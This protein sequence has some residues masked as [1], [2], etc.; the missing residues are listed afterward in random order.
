VHLTGPI[1]GAYGLGNYKRLSFGVFSPSTEPIFLTSENHDLNHS[2]SYSD[3]FNTERKMKSGWNRI[4]IP[5]A[6]VETAPKGRMLNLNEARTICLF[7]T[8][9]VKSC[10]LQFG[11]FILY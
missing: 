3:R 8:E 6:L 5:L 10:E 11:D 9:L 2:E 4:E 1:S 7:V